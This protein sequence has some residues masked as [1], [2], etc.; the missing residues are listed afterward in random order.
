MSVN[1]SRKNDVLLFIIGWIVV[2]AALLPYLILGENMA[3]LYQDQLDGEVLGYMLHAKYLFTGIDQ[4]PELMNGIPANGLFPPAPLLILLYKILPPSAAFVCN[5]IF[6]MLIAYVGMYLCL[7][8]VLENSVIAVFCAILFA[9]L[10]L[11]SV[12][13]LCQYGQ[14]LLFFAFYLLYKDK[15]KVLALGIVALYGFMS[16]LVLVGYAVLGFGGLYLLWLVWK[17]KIQEHKW[18]FAGWGTLLCSYLLVNYKLLF[19]IFG[20]GEQKVSHKEI[21]VR[22]GQNVIESFKTIFCRGTVHTPT[23]QQF[24]VIFSMIIL[25]SGAFAYKQ[26]QARARIVF[27][28]LTAG[29]CFNLFCAMFYAF[30]QSSLIAELRNQLGGIVKEFQLDRI[31]WLTVPIWYLLLGFDLYL[32]WEWVQS[33]RNAGKKIR[34][35]VT[36]VCLS[37]MVCLSA[38]TV[39][40]Y[41]DFNKNLHRMRLGEAYD[42]TTWNDFYAPEIFSQIDD[43]IGLDKASYRTLSFGIYPAAP[44]YNGFYCLDGYSNNYDLSYLYA[45][46][47]IIKDELEKDDSLQKYYDEWGCRCY[48]LSA[49]LGIDHYMIGKDSISLKTGLA[50]DVD[51]A[52]ELGA[53]YLFSAVKIP[54][55]QELGITLL[56][57]NPFETPDSYY[58]I[59][60]YGL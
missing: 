12:Y 32:T 10:P 57:E 34:M 22:Y 5:Q 31:Y 15:Q 26:L 19:Q 21:V 7:N 27:R 37:V 48:V 39:Y 11:L 20:I 52:R 60:L 17:H 6:C 46:R 35:A 38:A 3:V 55:S 9:Y 2:A 53:R 43:F 18:L 50:L 47:N 51:A 41:S 23:H 56:R 49:E 54:N 44:L 4:Y 40:Y 28:L 36:M 58:A 25:L 30:Y 14:P 42:K 33:Y 1:H 24:I 8:K 13:G 45:F 29:M 16:S 59:Y